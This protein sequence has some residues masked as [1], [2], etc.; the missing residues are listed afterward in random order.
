LRAAD[1]FWPPH[2]SGAAVRIEM[3]L[4]PSLQT[5]RVIQT[6]VSPDVGARPGPRDRTARL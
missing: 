5:D 6:T 2:P 3:F 4:Q 1:E